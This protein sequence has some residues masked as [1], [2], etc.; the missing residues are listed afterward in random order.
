MNKL[1]LTEMGG[2]PAETV[3]L[4]STVDL[5]PGPQDV[6]VAMEAA[7]INPADFLL[8]AGWYGVRPPVPAA[9]GSEGVGRV[10]AAGSEAGEALV[11]RRVLVLPTYEQ[12]TWADRV[13]VP[14]RNTVAV[15]ETADPQQLAMLPVNPATAHLL[16]HRY[17]E[18]HPG[19]WVGLTLGNSAVGQYVT[20]LAKRA[21]LRVLSVVRREAAAERV[22]KLGADVVLLDGDDLTERAA[23]AIGGDELQAVFDGLGGAKAGDLVPKLTTGGVVVSFSS[24]T[25]QAPVL[26]LGDFVFR[27]IVHHGL[28]VI[29]WVRS[30]PRKEIEHTYGELSDLVE[31][32]ILRADVEATYPISRYREAFAHA[33]RTERSGKV[34][35]TF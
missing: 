15:S 31:Q 11:G 23:A 12:G 13:V 14:I 10:V 20:A 25:G 21:G 2:D 32:G 29:N 33:Q 34:L 9:M 1:V 16:L 5:P 24:I 6:L 27:E 22:R 30:A 7:P 19:D 18:L 4:E 26:P 17:R 28:F 3:R 8:A 35:F